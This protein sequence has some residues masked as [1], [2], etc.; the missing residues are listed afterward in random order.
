MRSGEC[1]IIK[2]FI[3]LVFLLKK[4]ITTKRERETNWLIVKKLTLKTNKNIIHD[5]KNNKRKT[6]RQQERDK[7]TSTHR[8]RERERKT[9]EVKVSIII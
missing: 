7:E 3:S 4:K 2:R 6:G 1:S 8:E 9:H 5:K